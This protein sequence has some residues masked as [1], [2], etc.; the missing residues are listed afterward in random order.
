M[1]IVFL[2]NARLYTT[3]STRA[4]GTCR[5]GGPQGT[6]CEWPSSSPHI[7]RQ[8][9]SAYCNVILNTFLC[10]GACW[11][12]RS[13]GSSRPAGGAGESG[14]IYTQACTNYT[15]DVIAERFNTLILNVMQNLQ[16]TKIIMKYTIHVNTNMWF[17]FAE[18]WACVLLCLCSVLVVCCSPGVWWF[19]SWQGF[20]GKTGPPGPAGVVGPQV[21]SS[22][23]E[24]VLST[25]WNQYLWSFCT[26]F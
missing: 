2:I 7:I 6:Q 17:L 25:G 12:G 10:A 20:Q 14:N 26:F 22:L 1:L 16:C 23:Q 11:E 15:M 9:L 19:D 21:S 3:G 18:Y 4:S 24:S 8:H 5:W 13:A